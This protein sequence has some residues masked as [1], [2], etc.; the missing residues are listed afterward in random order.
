MIDVIRVEYQGTVVGYVSYNDN[1]GLGAFEYDRQF[2]DTGIELSPL[3]MPL[4]NKIYQ[5][6]GLSEETFK[7]ML[8]MIADSLPDDFG[9]EILNAW[10][11][12]QGRAPSEITRFERLQRRQSKYI[13]TNLLASAIT[14][15]R[16]LLINA[17][18]P[19]KTC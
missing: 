7:G 4:S 16:I 14:I 17:Y 15:K 13:L 9:N 2:V 10:V 18:K 6:P 12:S 11:A 3:K 5:F 1:T 19:A 8:G